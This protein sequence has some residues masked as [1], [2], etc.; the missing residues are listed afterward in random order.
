MANCHNIES[1]IVN[2]MNICFFGT[3]D[4]TFTSNLIVK[5]G[6]IINGV[7]VTEVNA[8]TP[9]SKMNSKEDV[10]TLQLLLRIMKKWH[11][12]TEVI[13]HWSNLRGCD[14]IYVGYPGHFDVLFA[15]MIKILLKKKLVFNPLVV[16]YTGF[17]HDQGI[18]SEKSLIAMLLKFGERLIYGMCDAVIADTAL[19]AQHLHQLFSIP[20][21]KIKVVAIGADDD[22]YKNM[23]KPSTLHSFNIVYYGLY[24]PLHGVEHIIRA[25]K[26]CERI[27]PIRFLMIGKGNTYIKAR[28]LAT[29]LKSRNITFYPDMTEANAFNTLSLA[30]IFLGFLQK[31]P[32]VDRIIPNKV[33][34]GLAMGKAVISGDT[35]VMREVF[36]HKKN[37]YLCKLSNA[38]DLASS[39]LELYRNRKLTQK[40]AQNGYTIFKEKFTPKIIGKNIIQA[41]ESVAT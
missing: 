33:Y 19:Q 6:L 25:A 37:V 8:H 20:L 16:F 22:V 27:N 39:I 23:P 9:I 21:D 35:P 14:W 29:S 28:K 7:K 32:S 3:Y 36:T 17:V 13:R 5:K 40:I 24:A 38:D 1:Q 34:Q 12:V 11:I 10:T 18:L 2:I 4:K 30:D 41:L 31:H 15:Y 26:K